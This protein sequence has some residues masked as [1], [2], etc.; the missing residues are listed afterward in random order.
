MKLYAS[1]I[2][3]YKARCSHPAGGHGEVERLRRL[4]AVEHQ[5]VSEAHGHRRVPEVLQLHGGEVE[6]TRGEGS[7][8]GGGG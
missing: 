7:W 4:L 6:F 8:G 5:R 2:Y 1:F 3:M